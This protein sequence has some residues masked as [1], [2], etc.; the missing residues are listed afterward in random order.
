MP[1]ELGPWLREQRENRSWVRTEMARR[2]I[3]SGQ[4]AGDRSLPGMDSMCHN[5]YRWERG[6]D[7]PS[8]RYKLYYSHALGIPLNQ[9]GLGQSGPP[10]GVERVP[11]TMTGSQPA[12]H[13]ACPPAPS[14][15]SQIRPP[16][17]YPA[18]PV[19]LT[20]ESRSPLWAIPR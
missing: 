20:L 10:G 6:T 13:G 8:E 15:Q 12:P 7:N 14:T 4:A 17:R 18:L 16:P 11:G 5:I 9:F 19:S 2:L 3:R 1:G